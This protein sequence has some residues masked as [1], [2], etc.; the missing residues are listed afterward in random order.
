MLYILYGEDEFSR[1]QSLEE[2]KS[3]IG[4]QALLSTNTTVLEG[5]QLPLAQLRAICATVPFLAEK[6][7]VIVRG[8]LERFETRSKSNGQ[9]KAPPTANQKNECQSL[10]DD[11]P[12]LPE[13][14]ELVLVDGRVARNN[15]LLRA[16]AGK[17]QVRHFP[18][19]KGKEL[20]QWIKRRVSEEGG[21]ISPQAVDLLAS[22]VGNNLWI[23]ANEISKLVLLA[24]GNP[25]NETTVSRVASY[26][27]EANVFTMVDAILEARPGVAG[28]LLQQLLQEGASPAYLLVMLARQVRLIVRAKEL[29]SQRVPNA[30]IQSRLGLPAEFAL[31]RTMAQA[32]RY[33]LSRIKE[34]YRKL[35]ETDLAI[36]T[37]RYEPELAL[38]ILLAEL[39]R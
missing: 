3:G 6:R 27:Q 16:L 29:R 12:L 25:I 5:Q 19:L 22:F 17:A 23:M 26:A 35:L 7:L 33:S 1:H 32:D 10:A 30:E 2:I 14:T 37:G 34:V 36:K 39:G 24:A 15:P 31:R 38:N 18:P 11:L 20:H 21:S 28:R 13:S 4:D 8:L 9:K